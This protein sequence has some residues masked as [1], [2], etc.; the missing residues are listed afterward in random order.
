MKKYLSLTIIV[1]FCCI[2]VAAQTT[3][4]AHRM[5][6]AGEWQFSD[7]KVS[8]PVKLPGTTDTNRLGTKNTSTDNR[9]HPTRLYSFTGKAEYSRKV[10]IPKDW[11]GLTVRL[12]LERTKDTEILV[13]GATAGHSGDFAVPQVFDLS[14]FLTPGEHTL[15]V[16]VDNSRVPA[17]AAGSHAFSEN[18]QTN[19]NGIL[20][21]I[22]LEALP[23]NR[24]ESMRL[25]PDFKNRR[26]TVEAAVKGD[27][28]PAAKVKLTLKNARTG[29]KA[30]ERF[31][32]LRFIKRQDQAKGAGRDLR[33]A[34]FSIDLG[35]SIIPWDEFVPMLYDLTV[36]IDGL[37]PRIERFGLVD[38]E[39]D[40]NRLLVNGRPTFLR[41]KHDGCV[42]PL[43]GH[44]PMDKETWLGYFKKL[45]D[46]GINHVRF[47]SWCPPEAAFAAADETGI[48]LQPELAVWANLDELT[49]EEMESIRKQGEEI[50]REYGN[51][52][53]FVMM[54]LGNELWGDT[55][56]MKTL[57]DSFRK[58]R[59]DKLYAFG[60]NNYLG[61]KG[62]TP[63]SDYMTTVRLG[64]ERPGTF[65]TYVRAANS[66]ADT[67][68]GGLLNHERPT[69]E[70]NFA[71]AIK[72]CPVPVISHET[73]QFQTY[74]DF[75]EIK[76]WTGVLYPYNLEIFRDS[77]EARGMG[78]M[79][80]DFLDASGR[81]SARLYKAESE[82]E[83]RTPDLAGYQL[84]DLQDYPGQ[85]TALVG[86]FDSFM[87]PKGVVSPEEIKQYNSAVVPLLEA[88]AYC[89]TDSRAVEARLLLSNFGRRGLK[90]GKLL[91]TVSDKEGTVAKGELPVLTDS[92][93]LFS[94]GEIFL[95]VE[96]HDKAR[97]LDVQLQILDKR[98]K[99]AGS[100]SYP[101][102]VYP[103]N[104]DLNR[105]GKDV[106]TADRLT[107]EVAALLDDG[108]RVLLIPRKEDVKKVT[109]PG[110]FQ[111]DFWNWAMFRDISTKNKKPV[112]PGTLSILVDPAHP[113]F[114]SFPTEKH[115]DMQ[116]FPVLKQSYPLILD[117]TTADYRPVIQ[118]IDN[119][120]R[121]HKLGI[122]MEYAVG[123]GR[124]LICMSDLDAASEY[125]EGRQFY[126]SLLEYMDSSAFS[127]STPATVSDINRLL[128]Q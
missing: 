116:W 51:H 70:R 58:I 36:E 53:S 65:S 110:N 5:P 109:V 55:G 127:P 105:F 85:G 28:L 101:L 89:Y 52:P 39:A 63:G 46:C 108:A 69:L 124:I 96:T 37:E 117:S 21:D 82:M 119:I 64:Q 78:D 11:K 29:Q 47:H 42:F 31:T 54:S 102:W 60:S 81:W 26:L 113:L 72:N 48:Y 104:S 57:T 92:I 79:A 6:L 107:D 86:L 56:K 8:A 7:G 3:R 45:R 97:R 67:D 35:Q 75:S 2:A 32:G 80:G 22:Y 112:A 90:G 20:G 91:W 126:R 115:T 114:A 27:V 87:D 59:A 61:L 123:N 121:N 34:V 40:G 120:D 98:G 38:F 73:G 41:G 19:W 68:D 30:T 33:H 23:A 103:E 9:M 50:V 4:T 128:G 94:L 43:T 84:L 49:P 106:V 15:T 74:P 93:G 62:Y 122:V 100:N 10:V 1:L 18:T 118:M 99:T 25:E 76:K 66:Y 44:A 125:P 95:P 71:E 77:L 88:S 17:Y 12:H 83:R 13:D 14:E 24:I 111:A 16:I